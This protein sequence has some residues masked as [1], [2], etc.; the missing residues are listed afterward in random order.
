MKTIKS[1]SDSMAI[2]FSQEELGL[3]NNAL[4]EVCN[5]IDIPEFQTRLGSPI[6]TVRELLKKIHG[7]LKNQAR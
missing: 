7:E 2:E 6:E 5:G 3:I 1:S 4:N